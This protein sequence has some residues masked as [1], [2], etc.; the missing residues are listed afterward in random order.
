MTEQTALDGLCDLWDEI[1]HHNTNCETFFTEERETAFI[2][3]ESALEK[4]IPQKPQYTEDKQFAIC[5]CNGEGLRGGWKFCPEC[6]QA[7][8]WS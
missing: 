5:K 1:N 4:Q 6:G 3:A 8:D 7:I 2:M